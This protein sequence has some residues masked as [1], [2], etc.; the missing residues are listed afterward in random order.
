[1]LI[2]NIQKRTLTALNKKKIYTENDMVSFVPRAYRDYRV[3][4][5][6][7]GC[8]NGEYAAVR[9]KITRV[10]KKFS[11]R[12][13][14]VVRIENP[15][16]V[17]LTAMFFAMA[18][19]YSKVFGEH[20]QEEVVLCGKVSSEFKFG[21]VLYSMSPPEHY[22][23]NGRYKPWI[24]TI[25][26][27]IKGVSDDMR[28][29]LIEEFMHNVEEPLSWEI[30]SRYNLMDY[31]SS[32]INLHHPTDQEMINKA[33]ERLLFNDLLYFSIL[34]RMGEA[35]ESP[36]TAISFDKVELTQDF[37]KNL[38]FGLTVDQK[39]VLNRITV[40]SR[41][42]MRNN[43]LLQGDVGCGKT[44]VAVIMM[45]MAYEN[46]YQSV[47]M[48]P[49]EVLAMQHFK[50]I[51][52]YA[53]RYGIKTCFLGSKLKASDKKV[54]YSK[55]KSGEISFVVGTHACLSDQ[56]EYS[57]LGSVI[58]DE[59][60]LFGVDQ[61]EKL[62]KK[63]LDGVHFLSMSATP[64]PRTL[65]S[66]MYGTQKEIMIIRSKPEGRK[67]V[68]TAVQISHKNILPF[69]EKQITEGHQCYV[70][71]PAIEESDKEEQIASIDSVSRV[72]KEYFDEKGIKIGIVHGKM[73]K[74]EIE[75][76]IKSFSSNETN[77]L[78]ST[79]VIEVGVNV[80]NA[81]VIVVE[82]AERFGLASLHQLRG[83]VGRSSIQSYC[84][85]RSPDPDNER[86]TTMTS[87]TDGFEI[88]DAD[89]RQ[90]GTGNLIG[91]AQ[92]GANKYVEE[93]LNN[94]ELFKKA[95]EVASYCYQHGYADKLI[96]MYKEHEKFL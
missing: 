9:G 17:F 20:M 78:I 90:R 35:H 79:T 24:D 22:F 62:E 15:N 77:I 85:L 47:L 48:A 94:P 13:Y 30:M 5:D 2:E 16:G 95:S 4:K 81:T 93:M 58:I 29:K 54:I 75:A 74:D 87:T 14:T 70:V 36:K 23:F 41:S 44:I 71:C 34:F 33:K 80:P 49:R 73:K 31:K 88:A 61:K 38:P 89:L 1:M 66:V 69:M 19:Y 59:E 83:R 26:P 55:I 72:Y 42:G 63:A 50:E 64:I 84:I 43:I 51:S 45:M 25:Y 92:S 86:L 65:A 3:L 46:G 52:S 60:H 32:L 56:I 37:I 8:K 21:K 57:R 40:N 10:N 18:D 76:V 67:P 6:I 82:Q 91:A 12:Y 7:A 11:S 28:D 68:Q 27:N 96:A 53:E 39:T